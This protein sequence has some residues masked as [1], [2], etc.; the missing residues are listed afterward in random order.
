MAPSVAAAGVSRRAGGRT[1]VIPA[2]TPV[3]CS[4][5]KSPATHHGSLARG[6]GSRAAHRRRPMAQHGGQV[7]RQYRLQKSL[8]PLGA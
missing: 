2:Q 4:A 6:L 5:P 8:R 7:V 1:C 3:L